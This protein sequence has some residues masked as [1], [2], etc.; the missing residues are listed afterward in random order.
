MPDHTRLAFLRSNPLSTKPLETD[1]SLEARYDHVVSAG[2]EHHITFECSHE[3]VDEL[4]P[5]AYRLLLSGPSLSSPLYS[6]SSHRIDERHVRV[7]YKVED[8]GEYEVFAWPEHIK[9]DQFQKSGILYNKRV[10]KGSPLPLL[11]TGEPRDESHELCDPKKVNTG[12]EGRWISK[13][14]L[15]PEHVSPDSPH[16][17]WLSS[18]LTPTSLRRGAT[19]YEHIYAPLSCKIPHHSLRDWIDLVKPESLVFFGD[20]VIRDMFCMVLWRELLGTP[21]EG[22]TCAFNSDTGPTGYHT[23]NKAGSYLRSDG[24]LTSLRFFWTPSG[25]G[26]AVSAA[27][28]SLDR[29][30]SHI[31]I[32]AALWLALDSTEAYISKLRPALDA[33][34]KLA[35]DAKTYIRGSAG[36]VQAIQC[37]DRIGGQRFQ[38]EAHNAALEKTIAT[39]YPSLRYFDAYTTLN[40]HPAS[41][42]DGRHWGDVGT[43]SHERPQLGAGEFALLDRAFYG[44]S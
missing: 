29:P 14:H 1:P 42:S 41:S 16:H 11:V 24:G 15:N 31:Y 21:K 44:W 33:I 13:A 28:E 30:P 34:V 4:C 36:V 43:L 26:T 17:R 25:D 32:S 9:C 8:P 7:T 2:E 37:Y 5:Q 6:Q 35:P 40:S 22:A 19:V 39:S 18:Q 3:N 10:V 27:L 38:L 12:V 20:S 23:T